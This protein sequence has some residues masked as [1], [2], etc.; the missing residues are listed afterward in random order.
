MHLDNVLVWDW[1]QVNACRE[2]RHLKVTGIML[3]VCKASRDVPL[4][5]QGRS[6]TS[7]GQRCSVT[8]NS[9]TTRPSAT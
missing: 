4:H 8:R 2:E 5:S 7:F 3:A 6:E 9:S 1:S